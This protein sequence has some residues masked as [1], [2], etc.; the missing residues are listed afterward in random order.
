MTKKAVYRLHGLFSVMKY[1]KQ[2][3]QVVC[4]DFVFEG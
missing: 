2:T 1:N 4:N 3:H